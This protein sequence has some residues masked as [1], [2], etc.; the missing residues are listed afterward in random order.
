MAFC[1]QCGSRLMPGTRFCE[2][3]GAEVDVDEEKCTGGNE[4]VGVILTR[5]SVLLKQVECT[6]EEL[7]NLIG[8]Y[9]DSA[10]KR[11]IAYRYYNLDACTDYIG[12][13]DVVSVVEWLRNLRT[14]I[15]FKYVFILGNEE[16][17]DVVRWENGAGDVDKFVEGDFAYT[18]LTIDSPWSDCNYDL[19]NTVGVGRLPTYEGESFRSF[20]SYFENAI[21]NVGAMTRIIPY[22]L[23]ALVWEE[24]S[25]YAFRPTSTRAVAVSPNVT[26][27]RVKSYL[28]LESNLLYF[29]LH[30]SDQTRFWYGQNDNSYPEA[31]E[32][33]VL[34][35]LNRAYAIGVEACYG[36]RYLGGLKPQDSILLTALENRCISFLGSSRIA[37]GTSQPTGSCADLVVGAYIHG[38][39]QGHSAGDAYLNGICALVGSGDLDDTAAKTLAEFS[40]YGDPSVHMGERARPGRSPAEKA[41]TATTG[42][43]DVSLVEMPDIRSAVTLALAEVDAKIEALVDE[44][45]MREAFVGVDL[46]SDESV[47]QKVYKASSGLYQ[48]VYT[49]KEQE[50]VKVVK[51]YF[52]EEGTVCKLLL[53]K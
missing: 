19:S 9:I 50:F 22:G 23:S 43:K 18:T 26:T 42:G 36:A 39:A 14:S 6:S 4:E 44:V 1:E 51:A 20:A 25:N 49:R 30:G 35:D 31:F 15:T 45:V 27:D 32:P 3:C 53:S 13:G 47:S 34:Q 17:L 38:L 12:S 21:K 5:E 46:L 8:R 52:D 10:A 11:G 33:S 2:E 16:V 48:K 7:H 29:N 40:L 41:N 28:G 24:E 37:Y